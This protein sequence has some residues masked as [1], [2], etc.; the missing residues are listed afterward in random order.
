MIDPPRMVAAAQEVVETAGSRGLPVRLL[1]GVAI[2]L[3]ATD[4]A[5]QA[6]G[7]DYADFDIVAHKRESRQ[8]R[9]MLEE[10]GFKPNQLFNAMHGAQR[11]MYYAGDESHHID[12]FLDRF[13]MSHKFDFASRLET[14]PVTL[15]AAELLLTKLQVAELNRKDASDIVML[16]WSC[17]PADVDAEGK[18]NLGV[19]AAACADDWG[20]YTTISDN[21]QKTTELLSEL[22]V[23]DAAR[24]TVLERLAR[25]RSAVDEKPKSVRWKM[26]ARVGR[27]MQWYELPEEV[28]R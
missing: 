13:E 12:V 6:L 11:L 7:R 17:E 24:Q 22:D 9:T 28:Q 18:L 19:V 21:L 8:L 26:R 23:P 20:L 4:E 14:E 16:L 5:R 1:G 25:V 27:R 3:R 2:W 10:L 15:P